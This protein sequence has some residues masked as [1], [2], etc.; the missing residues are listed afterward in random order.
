[1]AAWN[2][3]DEFMEGGDD[4]P[5]IAY[6]M[7]VHCKECKTDQVKC[8]VCMEFPEGC[9]CGDQIFTHIWCMK[10]DAQVLPEGGSIIQ[11]AD[12]FVWDRSD[13]FD[14]DFDESPDLE[15]TCDPPADY[16][17]DI[18]E[19]WRESPDD[20]WD[21]LYDDSMMEGGDV[22]K[23]KG[24]RNKQKKPQ[25]QK[26]KKQNQNKKPTPP[27]QKG[28]SKGKGGYTTYAKD[29]H[30]GDKVD[31]NGLTVYASSSWSLRKGDE[32]IP[33]WGLYADWCWKPSSW[34]AEHIAWPDFSIP[35]DLVL[36]F[37]QI[38]EA[39]EKAQAGLK[40]EFGCIGGH[41][42]TGTILAIVGVIMG[43]GAREAILHVRTTYCTHAIESDEQEW[44]VEWVDAQ[45][46]GVPLR[47][48]PVYTGYM[49][50][51]A[52][53]YTS[54]KSDYSTGYYKKSDSNLFATSSCS[55]RDHWEMWMDGKTECSTKGSSCAFFGKDTSKFAAGE[56]PL[57]LFTAPS[58]KTPIRPPGKTYVVDGSG[59][60]D[61]ATRYRVPEPPYKHP[62]HNKD[63]KN[64]KCDVCRY[65]RAGHGAF[66]PPVDT[67]AYKAWWDEMT[68]LDLST[69]RRMNERLKEQAKSDGNKMMMVA[70]DGDTLM[71][72]TVSDNFNPQ[73][74]KAEG[75]IGERKGEFVYVG[76]HA[77]WVWERLAKV[78]ALNGG[79]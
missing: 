20:P 78:T 40:V 12:G 39:V 74:P 44:F 48:Q 42:R 55:Q 2:Q 64:C 72:I 31:L 77:G 22:G 9:A 25:K 10:C 32:F 62:R 52:S 66:L 24:K 65:L 76:K 57:N 58:S 28:K 35:D 1:M 45:L 23:G 17:C 41:G 3:Y 60:A 29:R 13:P 16:W 33:D 47:E 37:E 50:Y 6:M 51:G 67:T 7:D 49:G 4:M 68:K 26:A 30:Y 8:Y 53:S 59:V 21:D 14:M 56:I 18:C 38:L 36:T 34:R 43:M 69:V 27:S 75:K 70:A 61:H 15:C 19:V 63:A 5:E 11:R 54:S 46:N 73:P 79:K 71:E